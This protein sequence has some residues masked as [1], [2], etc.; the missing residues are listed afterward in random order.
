MSSDYNYQNIARW[1]ILNGIDVPLDEYGHYLDWRSVASHDKSQAKELTS[2]YGLLKYAVGNSAG[3]EECDGDWTTFFDFAQLPDHRIVLH[4]VVSTESGGY[5][6][7][8][9]YLVVIP[10]NAYRDAF[11][12]VNN[13][14]QGV[15][16]NEV[17]HDEEGWNQT[18]C[19]FPRAIQSYLKDGHTCIPRILKEHTDA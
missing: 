1:E 13:A 18:T 12:M 16:Y 11:D 2:P 6:G 14:E 9:E 10:E 17:R 19:Y 5:I 15:L 7:D 3:D 8:G 4:S